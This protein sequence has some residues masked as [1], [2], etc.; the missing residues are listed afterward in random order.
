M[1]ASLAG[2]PAVIVPGCV[3]M[4]NFW[5]IET[6][7][8]RY[9][10]RNLYRWNPNITLLRTNIEE[11]HRIGEW[12]ARVANAAKGPVA[13]ALPLRGVSMLGSEG[14]A[15]WDPAAD[16]SCFDAIKQNL[17]SGIPVIEEDHN[18]NDA[19]FADRCAALLL[20]LLDE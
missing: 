8:E 2:I 16:Q 10:G 12:I 18:I 14:G 20:D 3:D 9:Q 1:A 5:S 17:R 15:F 6:V 19:E 13:I 4:A 7:P 11:N